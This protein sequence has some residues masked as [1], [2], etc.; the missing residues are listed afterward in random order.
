MGISIESF[1]KL[2]KT[3]LKAK[4]KTF[5][6]FIKKH[7]TTEYIGY[8]QKNVICQSIIDSTFRDNNN[9]GIVK[10]NSTGCYLFFVMKLIENYTDIELDVEKHSIDYYYDE[11]NKIGAIDVILSTIPESEYA[12]FDTILKMKMDDFR[13]NEYSLTALLYNLKQSLS[14]SD[15]LVTDIV[16]KLTEEA[17]ND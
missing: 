9:K 1:C 2:F 17:K 11:L 16:T 6:E 12:E 4:D 14:L 10:I 5:E 7:I 13:E 8:L 15:E 3:N